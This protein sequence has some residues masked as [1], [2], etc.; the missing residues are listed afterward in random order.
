[1][2]VFCE[3]HIRFPGSQQTWDEDICS[4]EVEREPLI[5]FDNPAYS[6]YEA[7]K[8]LAKGCAGELDKAKMG[9]E[10]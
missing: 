1:M 2:S 3:R 6:I 10:S 8:C 9:G 4:I 7:R 5:H